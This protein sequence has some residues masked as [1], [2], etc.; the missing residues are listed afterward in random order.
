[1]KSVMSQ[2]KK[3]NDVHKHRVISVF[4]TLFILTLS[5]YTHAEVYYV[6]NNHPQASDNNPGT[7]TEPFE[8]VQKGLTAADSRDTVFIK[9]GTYNMSGFSKNLDLHFL[10]CGRYYLEKCTW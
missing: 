6:D 2:R 10:D 4:I 9:N 8:T 3:T 1:M 7:E 5:M